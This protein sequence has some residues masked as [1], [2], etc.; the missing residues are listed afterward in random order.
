MWLIAWNWW[1]NWIQLF[2]RIFFA[3]W[4]KIFS[5]WRFRMLLASHHYPWLFICNPLYTTKCRVKTIFIKNSLVK[6]WT[7]ETFIIKHF[8]GCNHV[9]FMSQTMLKSYWLLEQFFT[10]LSYHQYLLILLT[11]LKTITSEDRRQKTA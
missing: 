11:N 7:F 6:D 4:D 1:T 3:F 5:L 9:Y 10:E 2:L 8:L